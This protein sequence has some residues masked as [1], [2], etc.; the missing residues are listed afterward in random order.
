MSKNCKGDL[1]KDYIKK[2]GRVI[3]RTYFKKLD[4]YKFQRNFDA[5][6]NSGH[7]DLKY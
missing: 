2:D 3:K 1:I 7:V 5:R 4:I 6:D